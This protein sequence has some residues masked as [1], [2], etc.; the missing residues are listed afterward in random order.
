M[1]ASNRAHRRRPATPSGALYGDHLPTNGI[2]R[3]R[4][5][6]SAE[7]IKSLA[8]AIL[9]PSWCNE[10]VPSLVNAWSPLKKKKR[11]KKKKEKKGRLDNLFTVR[12]PCRL[13]QGKHSILR[14]SR[15]RQTNA[16]ITNASR[17]ARRMIAK[18]IW[19]VFVAFLTVKR[20]T[21]LPRYWIFNRSF[22]LDV[23]SCP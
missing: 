18:K 16:T 10:T 3:F 19:A 2:L 21:T 20:P 17:L 9:T 6:K 13:T 15:E 4:A 5:K 12:P 22:F 1:R 14:A 8:S 7:V 11:K 23:V